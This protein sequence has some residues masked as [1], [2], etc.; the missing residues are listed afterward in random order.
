MVKMTKAVT[1]KAT[2]KA[3]TAMLGQYLLAIS[4]RQRRAAIKTQIAPLIKGHT[5]TNTTQSHLVKIISKPSS[6][7]QLLWHVLSQDRLLILAEY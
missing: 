2:L 4:V 3:T 1:K 7:A 6:F 5:P